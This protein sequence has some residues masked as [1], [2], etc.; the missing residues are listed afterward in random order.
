M[1]ERPVV[2]REPNQPE[3]GDEIARTPPIDVLGKMMGSSA[4]DHD[5]HQ[6]V[7]QLEKADLAGVHDF[8][9]T[10]R[11]CAKPELQDPRE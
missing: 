9:V 4:D 7:E 6:V 10:P 1:P 11:R 5:I 8:A 3:H 2:P